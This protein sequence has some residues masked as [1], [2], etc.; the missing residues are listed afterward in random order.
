MDYDGEDVTLVPI[1]WL[2][3]HEEIKEKNGVDTPNP[4]LLTK[5]RGQS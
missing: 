5:R 1:E 4:S 2:K 3:P